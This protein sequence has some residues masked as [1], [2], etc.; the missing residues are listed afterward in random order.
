[1]ALRYPLIVKQGATYRRRIPVVDTADD[2]PA[3]STAGYTAVGQ[4][5]RSTTPGAALLH[6]LDLTF[7]GTDLVLTIPAATSAGWSW[8][9]ARYDVEVTTPDGTVVDFLE[10]PVVVRPEIT[11]T[12]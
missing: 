9:L 11:R 3:D 2:Q 10:G 6:T 12:S 8:R 4:I 5:R 7:D 1:M